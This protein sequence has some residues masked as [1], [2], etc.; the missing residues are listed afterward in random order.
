MI[1][2][3]LLAAACALLLGGCGV[4]PGDAT[5]GVDARV[6]DDFG[7]RVVGAAA[8]EETRGEETV[9]RFLQRSFD[10]T[11]A[12][13]GGFVQSIDGVRGQ[14]EGGSVDWF[15]YV[16]GIE[17]P[18]GAASTRLFPGDRVW[19][20]RHRWEAAMHIPAV[21]GSW[22][23]PF[24]R[25]SG[26]ERYP[27]RLECASG[28]DTA[29]R[30][31]QGRLAA[32][33]VTAGRAGL[34]SSAGR[35]VLRLVVGPWAQIRGDAALNQIGRGAAASGVFARP[36]ASGDTLSVLNRAGRPART[37]GAGAG[38]IAATR[39]GEQQP[40]WAVTGTDAR[41][42]LAAARALG[43]RTL[44]DRFALALDPAGRPVPLP[45]R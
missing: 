33:G 34:G 39:L 27:V 12:Y 20:D 30:T 3:A 22:P 9:M 18:K 36:A 24:R 13:G 8:A 32:A 43:T 25:G 38:L 29:C 45:A 42:T 31:V 17:A 28:A 2:R 26:G 15:Y 6:T 1:H 41:G 16:N 40:T 5:K 44:R 23:E 10:V 19:W 4:G 11:T 14:G 35:D 21:V 7:A 37:L